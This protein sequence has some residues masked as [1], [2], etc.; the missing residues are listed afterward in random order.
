MIIVIEK[1]S[2][3]WKYEALYC[4]CRLHCTGMDNLREQNMKK[5]NEQT[6]F[7][8]NRALLYFSSKSLVVFT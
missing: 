1:L 8:Q 2:A 4:I 3:N 7:H 6:L 5:R